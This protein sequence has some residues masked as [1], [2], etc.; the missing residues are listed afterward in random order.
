MARITPVD[1]ESSTGEARELLDA[2]KAKVGGTPNL[3]RTM[4][5]SPA[6][7][8]SFLGLGDALGSGTFSGGFR[9]QIAVAVAGANSCEYCASAHTMIGKGQGVSKDEL[10]LN[11]NGESSDD[12]TQAAL[13]FARAVV[14]KRGLVSDED[15][16]RVRA[17]GF[18]EGEILQIVGEVVANT[19]TNYVNHVAQTTNDFPRVQVGE[20]VTA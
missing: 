17:A 3:I 15:L 19:L 4:A 16:T 7:L 6:V 1:H 13:G 12:K 18:A 11:L 9:E 2:V 8:K 10:A 5:N 14:A 20:P